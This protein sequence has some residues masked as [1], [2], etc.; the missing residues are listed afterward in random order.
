MKQLLKKMGA[1]LLIAFSVSS[2][3]RA[4]ITLYNKKDPMKKKSVWVKEEREIIHI[5]M[6]HIARQEYYDKVKQFITEKR[7]QGYAIYY[8]GVETGGE[9]KQEQDTIMMKVRKILCINISGG[10][11]DEKILR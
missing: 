8:E 7:Q 9:T 2:C 3:T 11:D 5:P 6:I 4:F 1:I 10:Y